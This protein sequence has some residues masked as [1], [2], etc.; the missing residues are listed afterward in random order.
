MSERRFFDIFRIFGDSKAVDP[1]K[2]QVAQPDPLNS[3]LI[4]AIRTGEQAVSALFDTEQTPTTRREVW[5]R[6]LRSAGRK[7]LQDES[8]LPVFLH[9]QQLAQRFYAKYYYQELDSV[10]EDPLDS[11]DVHELR[12]INENRNLAAPIFER[13]IKDRVEEVIYP[14]AFRVD[15]PVIVT[16]AFGGLEPALLLDS[17]LRTDLLHVKP[18][19]SSGSSAVAWIGNPS[20][21]EGRRAI[22]VEDSIKTGDSLRIASSAAE[23]MGATEVTNVIIR[24]PS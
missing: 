4:T 5:D 15:K 24:N 19:V 2:A 17:V 20:V 22:L 10:P 9:L 7:A 1:K 14:E 6:L 12:I 16:V 13:I 23:S 18:T 8:F 3:E 11:R 21:L